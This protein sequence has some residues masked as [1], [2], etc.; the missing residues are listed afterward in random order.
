MSRTD[1]LAHAVCACL[2]ELLRADSLSVTRG[3]Y[4]DGGLIYGH[5]FPLATELVQRLQDYERASAVESVESTCEK[6]SEERSATA[7]K[8]D[9]KN[10]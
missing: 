5:R 10:R 3:K 1:E 4:V 6:P 2:L 9:R 7:R 8:R